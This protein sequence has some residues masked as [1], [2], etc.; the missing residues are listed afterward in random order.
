MV[1]LSS[2]TFSLKTFKDFGSRTILVGN[3]EAV[4]RID[5]VYRKNNKR[6]VRINPFTDRLFQVTGQKLPLEL[7]ACSSPFIPLGNFHD[8][9]G[10]ISEIQQEYNWKLRLVAGNHHPHGDY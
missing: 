1:Q 6:I 4:G 7:I 2:Q 8:H 10:I 5:K 9:T 3:V